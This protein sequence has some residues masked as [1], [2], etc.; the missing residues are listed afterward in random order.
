MRSRGRFNA[1]SR[2]LVFSFLSGSARPPT[3]ENRR[4]TLYYYLGPLPQIVSFVAAHDAAMKETNGFSENT[5]IVFAA[6]VPP[7]G[8]GDG[9]A[10]GSCRRRRHDHRPAS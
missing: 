4:G 7:L 6:I 10:G 1:V 8:G 5:G 9:R 2:V 3:R